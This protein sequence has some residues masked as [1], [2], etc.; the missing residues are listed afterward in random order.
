MSMGDMGRQSL[1]LLSPLVGAAVVAPVVAGYIALGAAVLVARSLF[2]VA[3]ESWRRLSP[4]R[5]GRRRDETGTR[6]A[7]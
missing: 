1:R 4:L 7:A 5:H 3:S 6:R 2:G